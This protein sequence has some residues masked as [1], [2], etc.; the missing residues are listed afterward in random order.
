MV[1]VGSLMMRKIH[2]ASKYLTKH[3]VLGL[4]AESTVE[5][6]RVKM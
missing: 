4:N 2:L 6:V 3:L 1:L 5:I